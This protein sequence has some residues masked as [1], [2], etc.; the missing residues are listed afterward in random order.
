MEVPW[1]IR[2]AYSSS[3]RACINVPHSLIPAARVLP[4]SCAFQI[5]KRDLALSGWY[6]HFHKYAA[7]KATSPLPTPTLSRSRQED[8]RS[9]DEAT[10]M[11]T[12]DGKGRAG[13]GE[14]KRKGH[15]G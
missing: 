15:A 12:D 7:G 1:L 14:R 2:V 4:F 11:D 13:E 6:L 10:D 3:C 5:L 9:S 8:R